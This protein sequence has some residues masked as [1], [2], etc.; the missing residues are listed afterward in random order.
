LITSR[1]KWVLPSSMLLSVGLQILMSAK[2]EMSGE[3][4]DPVAELGACVDQIRREQHVIKRSVDPG[5]GAERAL[6]C[7]DGA[8]ARV[9]VE[10]LTLPHV[11]TMERTV[12]DVGAGEGFACDIGA[13]EGAVHYVRAEERRHVEGRQRLVLD[14]GG[15]DLSVA[16]VD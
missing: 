9:E 14:V 7:G 10:E 5:D 11:G 13:G 6:V 15:V 8:D 16:D 4:Y 1:L 3:Y 2:P 12:F